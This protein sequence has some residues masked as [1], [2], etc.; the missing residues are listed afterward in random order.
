MLTQRR[1]FHGKYVLAFQVDYWQSTTGPEISI[2][3][4]ANIFIS[5]GPLPFLEKPKKVHSSL[6]YPIPTIIHRKTHSAQRPCQ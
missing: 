5:K 4:H 3:G 1:G 6:R 2:G